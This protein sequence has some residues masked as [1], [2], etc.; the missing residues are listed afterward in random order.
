[1]EKCPLY[2]K[3]S[4]EQ[5]CGSD[6]NPYKNVSHAKNWVKELRKEDRGAICSSSTYM[7]TQKPV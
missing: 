1:M 7:Y 5:A 6:Q 2:V 3:S 4:E